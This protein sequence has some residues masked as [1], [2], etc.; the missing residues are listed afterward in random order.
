MDLHDLNRTALN[1][2]ASV[3]VSACAGSGKTWLLVS[4]IVRALLEGAQP[5]E[6]LAI[7]FTRK[8]A[9]EMSARL[10][11]WLFMLATADDETVRRMLL[12]REVPPA[13]LSALLP[14]ARQL[15][16]RFL[17]AEPG[18]T[19]TTFHSWFLQLL[20]RAPLD[21]DA[22]GDVNLQEETAALIDEAWERF[23]S[24]V[25]RDPG[26][27]LGGGLDYLFR[28]YGL[29]NT[30]RALTGFL[31]RRADWWAYTEGVV[32]GDGAVPHALAQMAHAMRD[33]L[34][35]DIAGTLWRDADFVEALE[36]Y[37]SYLEGGVSRG[38][39]SAEKLALARNEADWD[40]RFDLAWAAVF[41][42]KDEPRSYKP[43]KKQEAALGGE[44]Q[45]RFFDLHRDLATRLADVRA[46]RQAQLSYRFNEAALRCGHALLGEYQSLKRDR[47][48]IDYADIEWR[49]YQLLCDS[50]HAI[51]MLCKLDS[52]Y[53][54]VLLDEFQDTNPLQWLTLQRWLESAA[55][56]DSRPQL[57]LVGDPK[58][59]IY[60]FRR[61]E[62]RLFEQSTRY[63]G[64]HFGAPLLTQNES[65]RCAPAVIDVVNRVFA[66]EPAFEGFQAHAAHHRAKPG[67]IEVLPLVSRD[68]GAP[69][70]NDA[71]RNP[72]VAPLRVAEDS[73]RMQEATQLAQ[74][75]LDIRRE[76]WVAADDRGEQGRPV[77]YDDI[78]ILVSRRTHLE[79]YEHALREADIPFVT[80]RQGGLLDT[81]EAQDLTA[82]L[83]FLVSPFADLKLAHALRSPV[84]GCSDDDLVAIAQAVRAAP[85]STWW[86]AL[87]ALP[88][89]DTGAAL[90]RARALL[91]QWLQR[92]DTL[93]VHDQLDRIYFE[94]DVLHRYHTAV[95]AAMRGA[96][97]ANLHAFMQRALDT[98]AGR[99]PSLPRFIAEL[100][101]LR[102]APGVEAP[103]EGIIGD[104][105]DAVHI[106]TVH[107]A[108]G[109]EAPIVWLL[110]A[111]SG[112]SPHGGYETLLDWPVGEARP[113][114]FSLWSRRD[115]QSPQQQ[116]IEQR[117]AA[118]ATREDLNLLYVAM[119][120]AKQ[121][122]IVSGIEGRSHRNSWYEK[123]HAAVA[124]DAPQTL[125]IG[126]S[127]ARADYPQSR[128]PA[129]DTPEHSD[130]DARLNHPLPTGTRREAAVTQNA[131]D[132]MRYGTQFHALMER[133]TDG[134]AAAR[135]VLQRALDVD[136][137]MFEA[138]WRDAR[139]I[140]DHPDY[141]R[142]FDSGAFIA[143]TNEVSLA[144]DGGAILRID[145]LVEFADEVCVLDY[146]TGALDAADAAL[147]AEYRAQV[148]AYCRQMTAAFPAKRVHG[149]IIF[150]G[151]G[152]VAVAASG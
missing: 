142:Y 136:D 15:Y 94:A 101:D 90:T 115:E 22:L 79:I 151:G 57:F 147:L 72:F 121:A 105:S 108:K 65:R 87:A 50:E 24:R 131:G 137:A 120:R 138:L 110:D 109:L 88:P 96:V 31:S 95:P 33:A 104:A 46:R 45:Q 107:G 1:P 78:M 17:T 49:T 71:W 128:M 62:A 113:V 76:W 30:R 92:A 129:S 93:P 152:H 149:L 42:D 143:A 6:I 116:A 99:Y 106:R 27:E 55:E 75:I 29:D 32:G 70:P 98:D 36:Q 81:L 117:E 80:S 150:A 5:S 26:N 14:V 148:G 20:R 58:Q 130:V 132:G 25:Q 59:S 91:S 144:T 77:R 97:A 11:E 43:N 82:L 48:V 44:G 85:G 139:S 23:A 141:R 53:R 146:K 102:K 60:R 69:P 119:T 7:T 34:D 134:S 111:A 2:A 63:L 10:R 84:F 51:Y 114:H 135:A 8:A 21:A 38:R 124:G 64:E 74:R 145:R 28:H 4:R 125:C 123:I 3:V 66:A 68:N 35:A 122:L 140:L 54:H 18:I 126:A 12:E 56:V 40:K 39:A 73:R 37:E 61:A 52:R 103:D 47:R 112:G 19:I 9:Q 13:R 41:N 16:E 89:E 67:R 83:E 100:A 133:L 127:L 118:L 86:S